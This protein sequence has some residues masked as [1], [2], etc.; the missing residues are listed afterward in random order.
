MLRVTVL[1]LLVFATLA[2]AFAV[3]TRYVTDQLVVTVRQ[4]TADG[5]PVVDSLRTGDAVEILGADGRFLKVRTPQGAKGFAV[6]Q[7]FTA[8][9]PAATLL[10]RT[11]KELERLQAE[12]ATIVKERDD[13]LAQ[14]KTAA[15]SGGADNAALQKALA[16]LAA[17]ESKYQELAAGSKDV[18][19]MAQERDQLKEE[20]AQLTADLDAARQQGGGAMP[21]QPSTLRWFFAGAS[22]L[23][24]GWIL[25]K[26]SRQKRRY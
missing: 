5:A 12:R 22:V 14:L 16:D 26:L 17:A 24:F 20:V 9:A 11:Q 18:A 19:A 10:A 8:E 21:S 2:P 7:Y 6:A 1:V 4:S 25:G 15:T 13:A 3:E 23:F